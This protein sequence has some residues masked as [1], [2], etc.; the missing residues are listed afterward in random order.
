M[1]VT[2][3]RM[4][5]KNLHTLR[6]ILSSLLVPLLLTVERG[7][8]HAQQEL[9]IGMA[10]NSLVLNLKPGEKHSGDITI[11]NLGHNS[12][13]YTVSIDGFRQIEN[14]AGTAIRLPKE[15]EKNSPYSASSWITTNKQDITLIPN[16]NEKL[17][18][19]IKVPLDIAYGEYNAMISF[20]SEN[21]QHSSTTGAQT[22]LS[23]GVPILIKIG[24]NFIE[25]AQLLDFSTPQKTYEKPN[26]DFH[27]QIKNIGNTHI[28]PV[29]EIVLTNIFNQEVGRIQFNPNRKSILRENTGTYET[30]WTTRQIL[31]KENKVILGPIKANLTITYRAYQPGFAP[32]TAQL[33]FWIIPWRIILIIVAVITLLVV[34]IKFIKKK[35]IK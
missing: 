5:R 18:F 33:S 34:L 17:L 31:S 24:D 11:W 29:G 27:T 32:L 9:S 8:I 7:N 2:T 16:K 15:E 26:L 12:T 10:P 30:N 19:E 35:R 14:K 28:S 3:S 1:V 13:K 21:N 25:K 23:S 20:I 4:E 6:I 22:T